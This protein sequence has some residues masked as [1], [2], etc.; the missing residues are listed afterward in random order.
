M[1][2]LFILSTVF[3]GLTVLFSVMPMSVALAR[4]P[5]KAVG[6]D[7][8]A[9]SEEEI[10]S[11]SCLKKVLK[12][13]TDSSSI[14]GLLGEWKFRIPNVAK[15][16]ASFEMNQTYGGGFDTWVAVNKDPRKDSSGASVCYV[17]DKTLMMKG[18]DLKPNA[19][20]R[21]SKEGDL[22]V[23][24]LAE[25]GKGGAVPGA[26]EFRRFEKQGPAKNL[27]DRSFKAHFCPI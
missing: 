12:D 25:P 8:C 22:L 6:C 26:G 9:K 17:D 15:A 2:R 1:G 13:A 16:R 19:Y 18:K 11:N 21:L 14:D 10:L 7:V 20:I 4:G 24:G 3:S 27:E 5:T 23:A